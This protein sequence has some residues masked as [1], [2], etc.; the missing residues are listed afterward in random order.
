MNKSKVKRHGTIKLK[1]NNWAKYQT[2]KDLDSM[3]FFRVQSDIF[4]DIK[5]VSLTM[6]G[7]YIWF[8]IMCEASR[9]HCASDSE[10]NDGQVSINLSAMSKQH[11]INPQWTRKTIDELVELQ[12]VTVLSR[13]ESVPREEKNRIDKNREDKKYIKKNENPKPKASKELTL[14]EPKK[15]L[16]LDVMKL[17]NRVTKNKLRKLVVFSDKRKGSVKNLL[18]KIPQVK[19]EQDFEK[20][21]EKV[22]TSPFLCGESGG[23][24]KATFDWLMKPDNAIKVAE[25]NYE[26]N[27][28][29]T[30]NDNHWRG[31]MESVNKGEL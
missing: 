22:I 13:D 7:R 12:M 27:T 15:D 14:S 5:F 3:K 1:I 4:Y 19:T 29:T 21:F 10:R 30:R 25:G 26:G 18:K 31:Q 17:Y 2:R 23:N 9:N 24:W 11:D 28:S 20:Y 8:F 16:P 6:T